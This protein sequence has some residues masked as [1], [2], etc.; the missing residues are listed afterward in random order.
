MYK[1]E[2]LTKELDGSFVMAKTVS[3][4]DSALGPNLVEFMVSGYSSYRDN[5][6]YKKYND[7]N[8]FC[9]FVAMVYQFFC[10]S[11]IF[12]FSDLQELID[13]ILHF[14]QFFSAVKTKPNDLIFIARELN[15]IKNFESSDFFFRIKRY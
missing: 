5:P 13:S 6:N 10:C 14:D 1:L 7:S 3:F 11:E 4:P 8:Y 9:S 15:R 2:C 12:A